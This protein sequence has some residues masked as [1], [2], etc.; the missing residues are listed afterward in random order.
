MY[1][2]HPH[3]VCMFILLMCFF[4]VMV[5]VFLIYCTNSYFLSTCYAFII[6][7]LICSVFVVLVP[8]IWTHTWQK[9][10]AS[11]SGC[12]RQNLDMLLRLT[13]T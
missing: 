13:L 2:M 7:C 1:T 5:M 9:E 10:A 4:I 6:F 3:H 8:R 12:E 11:D